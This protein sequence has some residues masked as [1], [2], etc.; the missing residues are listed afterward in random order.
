M[1]G[2]F[3]RFLWVIPLLLFLGAVAGGYHYFHSYRVDGEKIVERALRNGARLKSYYSSL[4]IFSKSNETT[5]RYFVQV[6]FLTPARYR[7]EIFTSYIGE[8]PPS[9]VFISDGE[10]RWIYSPEVGD[11]YLLSPS[12]SGVLSSSTFL[13]TSFLQELAQA[14]GVELLG[15]EKCEKGTYYLLKIIPQNVSRGHAWEKVWLEKR[16]LLPVKIQVFD[17][18]DILYRTITFKKVDLNPDLTEDIFRIDTAL[19]RNTIFSSLK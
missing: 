9:Q 14:R 16:S 6:W 17:E 10:R 5:Q 12:S 2:F 18:Y 4:E 11:Y 8:G 13:L 19:F 7:V 15:I 3:I 1:K